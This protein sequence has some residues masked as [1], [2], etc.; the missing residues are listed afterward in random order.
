M[1]MRGSLAVV[2]AFLAVGGL[3]LSGAGKYSNRRA[4]GFSLPDN[5]G[6]QHD[7]QDYRG[8]VLLVDIMQTA[9]PNCKV[10][11]GVLEQL[12]A[13]YEGKVAVLSVVV[14]P[15]SV[16]HVNAF[17]RQNA[18]SSP[19]LFDCGQAT[20]SYLRITPA[21]PTVRFPHLFLVDPEG[22]IRNDFDHDDADKGTLTA[23]FLSAE[24]DK[25]LQGSPPKKR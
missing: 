20:A 13:K 2:L 7:P 24:I 6:K 16:D 17:I 4:P 21:N 5:T 12:K 15:D 11:S 18:I 19:I 23:K 1:F 22:F 10:L 8:K 3:P 9:C 14:L 25:L